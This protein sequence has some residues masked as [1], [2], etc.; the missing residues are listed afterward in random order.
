MRNLLNKISD[1][2]CEVDGEVMVFQGI[3]QEEEKN[4]VLNARVLRDQC[5]TILI[6]NRVVILSE[7]LGT[8]V[9]L[10]ECHMKSRPVH[11]GDHYV[12][13]FIIPSEIIIGGHFLLEP[14]V[15]RIA[16][17]NSNLNYMF[18]ERFPFECNKALSKE[19]QGI[20]FPRPIIAS[21][22]Y[23]KICLY[24]TFEEQWNQNSYIHNVTAAIE[25]IFNSSL[26]LM[27]AV[28]KVAAA[29][30]LFSFFGNGY[31]SLGKITFSVG[32]DENQYGLWLNYEEDISEVNEI[33]LIRTAEF[34]TRFQ[35][36]WERWLKLHESAAP[37]PTLFYEIICNRSKN[38]NEFLNLSQTI[39]VYS[40]TFRCEQ[41]KTIAK[42]DPNNT[43]KKKNTK[44]MHKYKDVL[45]EYSDVLGLVESNIGDY[46]QGFSNMR[47]YYTHYNSGRYVE[48]TYDEMHSAIN[49]LR[50]V[51]LIIIYTTVGISHNSIIKRKRSYTF[52]GLDDDAEIILRYSK[53]GK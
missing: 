3:L 45:M 7:I 2:K 37:I 43:E 44:L 12:H 17:Y 35:E 24:Q 39:E 22:K 8:K 40:D 52:K 28:A 20:F 47:N 50:F 42:A 30:N 11:S 48:P 46:A 36:I 14:V 31:I 26:P 34:K 32:S 33:F 19:K 51:L 25:Y 15:N 41:A 53:K 4:I 13:A 18:S 10:V 16:V 49:I 38:M 29:R 1:F 21:D 5:Q 6:E 27:D 23:G 9:T